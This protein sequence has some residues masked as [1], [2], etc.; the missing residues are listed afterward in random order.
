MRF[1]ATP[2]SRHPA[3]RRAAVFQASTT[4]YTVAYASFGPMATAIVVAMPC[5]HEQLSPDNS[6]QHES[7]TLGGF[8]GDDLRRMTRR[9]GNDTPATSS[10]YRGLR[11]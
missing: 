6:H 9:R 3:V 11:I 4:R 1:T 7:F 8:D 10:L 5:S 2:H